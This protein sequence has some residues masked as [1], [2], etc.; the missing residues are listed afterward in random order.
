MIL[1]IALA[2]LLLATRSRKMMQDYQHPFWMK[3][4]GWLVVA[5]VTWMGVVTIINATKQL[6][7]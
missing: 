5:T 7:S 6:Y 4:A 3:L 1:P 2:L